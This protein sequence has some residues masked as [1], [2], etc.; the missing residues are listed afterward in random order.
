MKRVIR[1]PIKYES[2]YSMLMCDIS[3]RASI[4]ATSARDITKDMVRVKSS[5]MWA[6]KINVKNMGDDVGDVYVQFKDA[7]GGPGDVYVYY[8][9]PIRIYQ[10][11]VNAPSKGHYFW[12]YVRNKYYYRK[13]TGDKRA[14]L[15]NGLN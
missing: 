1:H 2:I 5:N 6:F 14:K 13:L 10:R 15:K 11:W 8:D 7:N 3:D 12:V 4:M 9:V